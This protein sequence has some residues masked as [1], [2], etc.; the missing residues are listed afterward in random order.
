[1]KYVSS[2]FFMQSLIIKIKSLNTY[3][4]KRINM[5]FPNMVYTTNK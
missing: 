1:M 3:K 2:E 4:Q 5:K